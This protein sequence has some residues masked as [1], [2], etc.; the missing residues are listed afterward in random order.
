MD[1]GIETTYDLTGNQ[2]HSIYGG[3]WARGDIDTVGIEDVEDGV[4]FVEQTGETTV[5]LFN[6]RKAGSSSPGCLMRKSRKQIDLSVIGRI[7]L[8]IKVTGQGTSPGTAPWYS[9]WLVPMNYSDAGAAGKAAEIDLLE[10]YAQWAEEARVDASGLYTNFAQCGID[11]YTLPYCTRTIWSEGATDVD[12]HITLK[13][14]QDPTDGRVIEV[15]HC[16]NSDTPMETCDQGQVASMKVEKPAD[17]IV[18]WFPIWNKDEVGDNYAKYW[19]AADMW[20]TSDT[21]FTLEVD[22]VHFFHDDDTEW[23]MPLGYDEDGDVFP[24]QEAE[25]QGL[26]VV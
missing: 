9:V 3:C 26:E 15:R 13:A 14:R 20:Y 22:N 5:K 16:R 19:L 6:K 17:D 8:D 4:K 1:H 25:S 12:H 23:K 7:E 24:P 11:S 2:D 10:N 18:N 21:D